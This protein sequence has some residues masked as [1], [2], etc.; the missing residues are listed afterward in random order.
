MVQRSYIVTGAGGFIGA[1]FVEAA[2]RAGASVISV[3]QKYGDTNTFERP[4]HR[5]LDFG[6][7]LDLTEL[8]G[9]LSGREA[10]RD[11][12]AIIHLGACTDTMELDEAVHERLNVAYSKMLWTWCSKHRVP[13][14]Y[15]SSAATYGAGEQGYD[16]DEARIP[17]L[18]PLNPYGWSKQ[19]FDLWALTEEREGRA[20]PRWAGFKFF[21]V[22]GFGER[23]KGR[24][25]SVILHSFDQIREKGRVRL[26]KSHKAGFADGEQKRDFVYV[27]DVVDVLVHAATS[28][29][30]RGIF[31][32]GTGKART[33]FDLASSTFRALGREPA[34]DFIDM[35]VELRERYQYFT[36]AEME[37]LRGA[38]YTKAFTSLEDGVFRYV[39]RLLEHA[40]TSKGAP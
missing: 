30:K 38:G 13:L 18:E 24:M 20:P 21:N 23:H 3:D 31:N 2:R 29:L 6:R 32:L 5:G 14:V 19:R 17:S 33:F 4:E 1:R 11:V 39:R 9:F 22:Y 8:E 12:T 7:T 36:E 16:D 40:E 10:P 26:F 28:D 27:E 15:A 25:A 37:R 34:I 35:P